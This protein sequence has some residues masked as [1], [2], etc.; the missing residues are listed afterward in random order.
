MFSPSTYGCSSDVRVLNIVMC[1]HKFD[2]RHDPFG[3]RCSPDNIC[4][5]PISSRDPWVGSIFSIGSGNRLSVYMSTVPARVL[6][7][8]VV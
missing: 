1:N 6:P 8:V 7:P 4:R 5:L 3:E 2:R